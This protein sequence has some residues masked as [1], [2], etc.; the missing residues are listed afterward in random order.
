M[1][2]WIL[3]FALI[4]TAIGVRLLK[5]IYK[6]RPKLSEYQGMGFIWFVFIITYP[7]WCIAAIIDSYVKG[8]I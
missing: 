1:N 4:Y 5:A 3:L 2:I 7:L 6:R 8:E